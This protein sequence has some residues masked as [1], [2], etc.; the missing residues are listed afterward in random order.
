MRFVQFV[1]IFVGAY[2]GPL[3]FV[4]FMGLLPGG[5]TRWLVGLDI[6]LGPGMSLPGLAVMLLLS[7][8]LGAFAALWAW[9]WRFERRNRGIS[10][11]D[12]TR[13][14]GPVA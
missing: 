12:R 2:L 6:P 8:T 9:R 5:W 10:G 13:P 7:A 3:P 4:F 11:R 1:W 14:A